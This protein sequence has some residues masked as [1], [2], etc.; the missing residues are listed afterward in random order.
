MPLHCAKHTL[1][2]GT[3]RGR[4]LFQIPMGQ[5]HRGSHDPLSRPRD[6]QS[7]DLGHFEHLPNGACPR[8]RRDQ[9]TGCRRPDVT[10]SANDRIGGMAPSLRSGENKLTILQ[11]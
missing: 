3:V 9:K 6:L 11:A 4:R 7:G 1:I 2:K 8:E 5:N 10:F